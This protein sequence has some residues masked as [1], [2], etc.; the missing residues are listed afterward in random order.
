MAYV[1]L[2]AFAEA[3]KDCQPVVSQM[4][5]HIDEILSALSALKAGIIT[6]EAEG[7]YKTC[8]NLANAVKNELA[9]INKVLDNI[10]AEQKATAKRLGADALD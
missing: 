2:S 6:S 9:E 7:M 4:T 8:S 5:R 1:D 3:V 10:S